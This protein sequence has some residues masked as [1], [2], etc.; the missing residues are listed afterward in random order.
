MKQASSN[1][2]SRRELPSS[3]LIG[4]GN[5]FAYI[6]ALYSLV[7][8]KLIRCSFKWGFQIEIDMLTQLL[9]ESSLA[10]LTPY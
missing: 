4:G 8:V 2:A 6:L 5:K 3:L 7:I 1:E 10:T 9:A